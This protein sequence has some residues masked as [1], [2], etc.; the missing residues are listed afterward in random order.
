VSY[1]DK[2]NEANGEDNRDGENHNRSWN[3][4]AEGPTDDP[5]VNTLRQRQVRNFLATLM[6]SQGVPMLLGGDEIGRTQQGN[7]NAYCQDN[8]ISWYDWEHADTDLLQ[9]TRRLIRLRHRHPVFCRRRWF[10]GRP[11]HGTNVSD[12]GWFTPAGV[13][14]SEDNW[15][16]GFA[17]TLG[18]FLNG[19]GIPTPNERG[20]QIVDETFYAMFNSSHEPVDFTLPETKWGRKWVELLDTNERED[21]MD[22]EQAGREFPCRGTV[23]VPAWSLALLRRLA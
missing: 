13:E 14:M 11:I 15:Q 23:R 5:K 7:N 22:E 17:K 9:F 3:C 21:E 20:E 4:G 1:N 8:E 19:R 18:V 2:H 16:A 12:I 10:Q 6:F